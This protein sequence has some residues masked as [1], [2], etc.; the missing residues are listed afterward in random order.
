MLQ[1]MLMARDEVVV[2]LTRQIYD[3]ENGSSQSKDDNPDE[4][5]A[6]AEVPRQ[7]LMM[8]DSRELQ[9]LKVLCV[10]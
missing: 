7:V 10:M 1:E 3:L 5:P 8:A 6:Q 4:Q 9:S 2:Q